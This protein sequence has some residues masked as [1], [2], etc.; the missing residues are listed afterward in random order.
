MLTISVAVQGQTETYVLDYAKKS[1]GV[2][3]AQIAKPGIIGSE[4]KPL[5]TLQ[6][7]IAYALSLGTLDKADIATALLDQAV[8]GFEQETLL[9]ADLI[10]IA[11]K[12]GP[13][14]QSTTN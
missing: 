5:S 11:Q 4:E 8:N 13:G 6:S 1:N 10:R 7:V 9:G 2:V 14:D 3:E 12:A